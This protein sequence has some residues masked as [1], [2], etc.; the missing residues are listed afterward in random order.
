MTMKI[1]STSNRKV[2]NGILILTLALATAA[3]ASDHGDVT[4]KVVI[5]P[6][7]GG[8]VPYTASNP[9]QT[10]T[11]ESSGTISFAEWAYLDLTF[12][13]NDGYKLSCVLKNGDDWTPYLDT[14][15]H[16]K[17]G[18]IES[19]H[20]ITA[21]F[22]EIV[23]T[24][25]HDVEF[26]EDPPEGLAPIQDVSGHYTGTTKHDRLFDLDAA[27]DEDGKVMVM[28]TV[29]GV[30]SAET[31]SDLLVMADTK[32]VQDTPTVSGKAKFAGTLDGVES[33]ANGSVTAPVVLKELGASKAGELGAEGDLNY[34]AVNGGTKYKDKQVP[35]K[36]EA[37]EEDVETITDGKKWDINIAITEESVTTG[38]KTKSVIYASGVLTLPNNTVTFEKKKVKYSA[39]KGFNISF[40]KGVDKDGAVD[41]KSKIQIKNMTMTQLADETWEI[42]GGQIKYAIMGQKGEGNLLDFTTD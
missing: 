18:P 39:K 34:A 20:T 3:F 23:P 32:T 41:K 28:G 33:T 40:K 38:K 21:I 22:E 8:V 31:G 24:G 42:S 36:R 12:T 27:A 2:K 37:S 6:K 4:W 9:Y 26:P 7:G 25:D 13:A 1:K 11:L 14:H 30:V 10:G 17:F 16:Y 19:K 15:N 35:I 29:T 5:N